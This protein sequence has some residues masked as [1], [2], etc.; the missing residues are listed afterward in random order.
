MNRRQ[1][2]KYR[3]RLYSRTPLLG[4]WLRRRAAETLARDRSQPAIEVL[5][6][7]LTRS[8]DE[9]VSAIALEAI[10]RID[11]Q[12]GVDAVCQVWADTRHPRLAALIVEHGWI[13]TAPAKA[14]VL[15]ALRVG[16]P[17]AI[18]GDGESIATSLAAAC[19]DPDP[20]IA[21]QA[22]QALEL[23]Q[24]E[25]TRQ[26]V[27]DQLGARWAGTRSPQLEAL[28]VRHRYVAREPIEARVLSALKMEQPRS[29]SRLGARVV[30]PLL[31]AAQDRDP[32]I[33]G[34]A[35]QALRQLRNKQAQE[36]VCGLFIEQDHPLA[37]AAALEAGYL[38][39]E[40]GQ[41]AL[42]LFLAEQW[43]RY[44]SL[45]FD[46][47][48]LRFAYESADEA[49]ARRIRE[50]IR[51][52][53]RPD[54]LTVVA[55]ED[56]RSRA[57][58]MS[59]SEAEFL[60]QVLS[61]QEEW[62]R[63]WE[64]AFELHFDWSVRIL[65]ILV[66]KDWRPE[67]GA[68]R[69][70]FESLAALATAEADASEQAITGLPPAIQRARVNVSGNIND[71]AFSPQR[72]LIAIGTGVRRV[73]LWNLQTGERE[74]V[75][76][77]FDH[78]IAQVRF[79]PD[80]T[81]FCGERTNQTDIPCSLYYWQGNGL[82]RIGQH[83]GS[84]TAVLPLGGE[85]V[86]STG[87]DW[88]AVLWF[89][90]QK[91]R[92]RRLSD[93][94]RAACASPDGT[95]AALLAKGVDIVDTATLSRLTWGHGGE[96]VSR[97]AA[98]LPDGETLLVGK[99]NGEVRVC[100][101]VGRRPVLITQKEALLQHPRP[102]EG[103]EILDGGAVVAT[104]GA[105]G[106]VRFTAWPGRQAIGRVHVAGERLSSLHVSPDGSFMSIGDSD[107]SMSL[108]DLRA[109]QVRKL[110]ER[111]LAQARP[112]DLA[113]VKTV[114]GAAEWPAPLRRALHY[115]EEALRRR[116]RYDI[117]IGELPEIQLGEFDIEIGP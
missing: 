87:R 65:Q 3:R 52:S 37:R 11:R 103:I 5:A 50:R 111:P 95:R 82:L 59:S 20:A 14:R 29:L 73:V 107:A 53:G 47:R 25:D 4:G 91:E 8:G 61:S 57:A 51:A 79:A 101:I 13:A 90:A 36:A 74:G 15:S 63:L 77:E 104:A 24:K 109:L 78:S 35:L 22:H 48:L 2:Q 9:R 83:A 26:A 18:A 72:P 114:G 46:R 16:R 58:A 1:V 12:A 23:L 10:R 102:V 30:E 19:E 40:A 112:A 28:I 113:A 108:W 39:E 89:R 98:F 100:Q 31:Q 117:E 86:L 33:A 76:G 64:L 115:L 75:L 93:W 7:A 49:L 97:C 60:V 66:Q 84:I 99:F 116:F 69:A 70:T 21:G 34:Q 110:F 56:Y 106:G 38:P 68:D 55:G 80:G 88:R 94:A 32:T 92:E 17:E 43:E 42:F 81:L 85:R 6:E 67:N 54:L 96:G 71:V 62:A 105:G 45:D 41:R 44:E 27:A